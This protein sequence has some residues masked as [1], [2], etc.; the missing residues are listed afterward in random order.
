VHT[1]ST[2]PFYDTPASMPRSAGTMLRTRPVVVPGL[3][4]AATQVVHTTAATN[5]RTIAVSGT[6]LVPAMSW[7]GPGPRPVLSYGVGV[8]GLGRDSAPSHLLA[9]GLEGELAFL[10]LALSR[11][12]SVVVTDG[13]GLGL[14]GPHTYGAGRVGGRAMLDIVRAAVAGVDGVEAGAPVLLWGYSEGGRC[15]AWAAEHQP[16]YARDLTLVAL[17]AGGVPTDLA[18]VVE[19]IDGGPYSGLGLAVL[20]GLAHAHEDPRLWDILNARGRAAAA[21]AATLD[22]TGLVVS[23]PEPMAAWTTRERPWE[24]PLWAALLRAER[25]PGGTP[26]VPVYL[27]HAKGDDIVPA[28]LSRQL[29][30]AYEA[31]GVHVTHVELDSGDHLTGAADGADAAITWLAEQL[32]AHLDLHRDRSAEPDTADE[33]MVRSTA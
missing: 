5:S 25:N 15:A 14:P 13:E 18:A 1:P 17:A 7:R 30:A 9:T 20:V 10:E 32:D 4:C 31:M 22:V 6:V 26:E 29:A 24:D 33:L 27:Y 2:D 21:V 28:E 12:W 23:H 8:H 19:A 16:I 11:G 3:T